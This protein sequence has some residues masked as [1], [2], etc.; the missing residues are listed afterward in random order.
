[1]NRRTFIYGCLPLLAAPLTVQAQSTGKVYRIGFLRRTAPEPAELEAF[2]QGLRELGYVEGQN[3]IIDQRYADG[4]HERLPSLARELLQLKIDVFVVDG[5]LSVR[6][7]RDVAGNRPI[8]FAVVSD[9][10][11]ERFVATLARPGGT[12]TGLTIYP[13]ELI[14]K[15][16]QLLVEVVRAARVGVLY[17]PPN[18]P[19]QRLAR[20]AETARALGVELKPVKASHS[21]ALAAAFETMRREGVRALLVWTDA[22]F[23]SQRSRIVELAAQ[24]RLPAVYDERQFAESGGLIS[25]GPSVSENFHRA[26]AFVDKILKGA[27]P[28]DLPVEEPTKLALV[29]N[30][31]TAKALGLTIPPAVLARADG[32][33]E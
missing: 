23:V 26:A 28:A 27:I 13:G 14:P 17:N 3:V 16:L 5:T 1:V 2:L 12:I 32:V 7:A 33:I 19:A 8:V 10:V 9:P 11:G 21:A 25:Y 4:V 29:I 24:H 22:M 15:R 18:T 30:L 20:L 6:A 31:K